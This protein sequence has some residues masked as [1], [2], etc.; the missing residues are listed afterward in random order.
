MDDLVLPSVNVKTTGA[1]NKLISKLYLHFRVRAV[2]PTTYRISCVRF[3]CFV[4]Q[5]PR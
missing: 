3:T 5:L 4:R 1:R 2:A